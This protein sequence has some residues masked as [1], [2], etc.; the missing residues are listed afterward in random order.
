MYTVLAT[1][2]PRDRDDLLQL[3]GRI[4]AI[5]QSDQGKASVCRELR[6][7]LQRYLTNGLLPESNTP[8]LEL[9]GAG[10]AGVRR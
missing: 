4:Q 7:K 10:L 9:A 3:V 5:E 1:M 2:G 8:P 6:E